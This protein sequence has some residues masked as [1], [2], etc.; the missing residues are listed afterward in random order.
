MAAAIQAVTDRGMSKRQAAKYFNIPRQTLCDH[1]SGKTA[2]NKPQGRP[3][4]LPLEVETGVVKNVLDCAEKG[5][6]LTRRGVLHKVGMC[7]V[8]Y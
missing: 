8:N 6:P 2:P 5:F 4:A 3:P 1:I 7:T